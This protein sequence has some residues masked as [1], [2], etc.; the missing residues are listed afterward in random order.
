MTTTTAR[1]CPRF[2]PLGRIVELRTR[3]DADRIAYTTP[4][5]AYGNCQVKVYASRAAMRMFCKGNHHALVKDEVDA[6]ML[7]NRNFQREAR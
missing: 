7:V 3:P 4:Y 5:S 6:T 2:I 1:P